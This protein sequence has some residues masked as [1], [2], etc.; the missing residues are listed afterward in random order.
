MVALLDPNREHAGPRAIVRMIMSAVRPLRI[1]LVE[2]F[3]R[4]RSGR[5]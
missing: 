4:S 3:G 5:D 2:R 1:F